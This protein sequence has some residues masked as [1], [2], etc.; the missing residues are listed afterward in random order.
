MKIFFYGDYLEG[1]Y[2]LVLLVIILLLLIPKIFFLS[3]E[4]VE[5]EKFTGELYEVTAEKGSSEELGTFKK[6]WS[7]LKEFYLHGF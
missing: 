5:G 1:L 2:R 7:D 6:I 4:F 3:I